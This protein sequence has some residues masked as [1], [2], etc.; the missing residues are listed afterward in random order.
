VIH[1]VFI[2]IAKQPGLFL[3][4]ADAYVDLA[5]AE[6]EEWGLR[7]KQRGLL[8]LLGGLAMA[9][10]VGLS[11]VAGLLAAAIPL[12]S[13]PMPWLLA[14]VPA[15][16]LLLGAIL[17]WRVHAMERTPPFEALRQQMAQDLATLKILDPQ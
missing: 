4:H 17:L 15:G 7:W 2:T 6:A 8:A 14:A 13:M 10:G 1:P 16:F 11:A 3:E 12:R 9:M 5:S